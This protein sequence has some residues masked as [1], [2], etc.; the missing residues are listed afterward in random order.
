[1]RAKLASKIIVFAS[2]IFHFFVDIV[3]F[4]SKLSIHIQTA[5]Q[6]VFEHLHLYVML[7]IYGHTVKKAYISLYLGQVSKEKEKN[8]LS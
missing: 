8:I 4:A 7:R 2:Q 5:K 6:I 1:M 3:S